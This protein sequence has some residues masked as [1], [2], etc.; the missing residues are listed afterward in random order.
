[1]TSKYFFLFLFSYTRFLL[2]YHL[3]IFVFSWMISSICMGLLIY[4]SDQIHWGNLFRVK[5]TRS[6]RKRR[7][8]MTNLFEFLGLSSTWNEIVG[9]ISEISRTRSR[10][11]TSTF[12]SS[13]NKQQSNY[14]FYKQRRNSLFINMSFLQTFQQIPYGSYQ[15]HINPCTKRFYRPTCP[16]SKLM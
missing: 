1:M 7:M 16:I 15:A 11:S 5:I 2:E 3:L 10:N 9:R 6:I 13:L 4:K 12:I 8:K 14:Y